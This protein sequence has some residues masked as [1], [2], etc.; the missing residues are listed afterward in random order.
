MACQAEFAT[1]A[2]GGVWNQTL[3]LARARL[4]SSAREALADRA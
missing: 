4:A 2:V 3:E 1:D